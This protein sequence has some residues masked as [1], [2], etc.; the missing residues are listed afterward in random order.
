MPELPDRLKRNG[1]AEDQAFEPGERL[2]RRYKR[3]HYVE[4]QFSNLG[5]AFPRQS[6]NRSKYS[7]PADVLFSLTD[8][9]QGWGVLVFTVEHLPPEFPIEEPAYTFFACHVPEEDNYSHTE[10]W[11]DRLPRTGNYTVPTRPVRKLFR[12]WLSQRVGIEIE[13][14]I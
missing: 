2:F 4:R 12:T 7:E 10:V 6:I 14:Q 1:R 8:A 13:A 3:E 5:F 9:F 11:C